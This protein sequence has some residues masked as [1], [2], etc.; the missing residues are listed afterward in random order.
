MKK[1]IIAAALALLLCLTACGSKPAKAPTQ[2]EPEETVS[3]VKDIAFYSGTWAAA[4]IRAK[5][6]DFTLEQAAAM[7]VGDIEKLKLVLASDQNACLMLDGNTQTGLWIVAE[8]GIRVG[9]QFFPYADGRLML[10]IDAKSATS[11]YFEKQS[12]SQE[13]PESAKPANAPVQTETT[14]PVTE[15]APTEAE[16]ESVTPAEVAPTEP[17][18]TASTGIRPE[19]KDA[20]DSYEAFYDDYCEIMA[21]YTKNPTDLS[22]LGK[23]ADMLAKAEEM[24]KKFNAWDE[25]SLSDEELKYYLDVMNRVQKKM[26]DLF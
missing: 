26:I 16:A 2:P 24:D 14:Q 3:D 7:G 4:G 6:V 12:D 8:D 1:K 23:Y 18:T 22:L 15:A 21:K 17:E 19:F 5:G 9:N 10:E 20:M 11:V 25:G 13:M